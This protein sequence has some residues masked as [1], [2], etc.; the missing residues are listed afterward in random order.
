MARTA[1]GGAIWEDLSEIEQEKLIT[2]QIWKPEVLA[3]W[4]NEKAVASE[5]KRNKLKK[6]FKRKGAAVMDDQ[7]ED[8]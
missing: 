4:L 7:D 6:K 8:D 1:V 5:E 3:N 2:L